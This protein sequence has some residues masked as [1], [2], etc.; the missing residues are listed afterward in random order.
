[1]RHDF[2]LRFSPWLSSPLLA[3]LLGGDLLHPLDHLAV[4]RLLD[5]DVRHGGGRRGTVPVL[6]AGWEP[7]HVARPNLFDRPTPAL[8][9]T[10]AGRHDEHLAQRVGVPSGASAGLERNA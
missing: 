5:R 9:P 7:D 4:E 3:V 1:M 6:L 2:P 8:R 10:A